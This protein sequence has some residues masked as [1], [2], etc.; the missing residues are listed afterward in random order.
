MNQDQEGWAAWG[1]MVLRALDNAAAQQTLDQATVDRLTNRVNKLES[2]IIPELQAQQRLLNY[3]VS[4]CVGVLTFLA[5][6]VGT[7]LLN[8]WVDFNP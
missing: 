8:H 3:K 6:G 1:N 5:L 7:A 2:Q 4:I